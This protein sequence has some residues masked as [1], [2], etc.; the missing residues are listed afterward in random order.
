MSPLWYPAP[1]VSWL[2]AR[3]TPVVA[4]LASLERVG[5]VRML[6][7]VATRSGDGWGLF[8]IFP[9][10]VV[11]AGG[12]GFAA[13]VCGAL[14]GGVAAAVV[15][16][17]KHLA[18]RVRP[19]VQVSRPIRAP[20]RWAFPS[21]HSAQAFNVLGWAW[22]MQPWVGFLWL[23]WAVCVALSRLV[24][25]L[26]YPS[27]VLVGALIGSVASLVTAHLAETSGFAMW[28]QAQWPWG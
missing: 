15:Q 10:L 25:G 7:L 20:D 6:M 24:F 18:K 14:S 28:V 27:D 5:W 4:R 22:W 26:H 2:S 13:F 1:M 9:F 11:V 21:G 16:G 3:E 12:R 19:D 17:V 23:P 8:F